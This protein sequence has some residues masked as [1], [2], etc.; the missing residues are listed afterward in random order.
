M[1]ARLHRAHAP[2]P[3][4]RSSGPGHFRRL[5]RGPRPS[6]GAR[7]SLGS[8]PSVSVP[9][10]PPLSGFVFQEAGI[11]E[12]SGPG[13]RGTAPLRAGLGSPGAPARAGTPPTSRG[14]PLSLP[15]RRGV[16]PR[17]SRPV[18]PARATSHGAAQPETTRGPHRPPTQ[19]PPDSA[20]QTAVPGQLAPSAAS[21]TAAPA[22]REGPGVGPANGA[23]DSGSPSTASCL[24]PGR[25]LLII[26]CGKNLV[27]ASVVHARSARSQ[28]TLRMDEIPPSP[29][30]EKMQAQSTASPTWALSLRPPS[31][32]ES[33]WGGGREGAAGGGGCGAQK[34]YPSGPWLLAQS[35][36]RL[37]C[38]RLNPLWTPSASVS[39][40][41]KILGVP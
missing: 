32:D 41:T 7:R 36:G 6:S 37:G 26:L 16:I 15:R 30:P 31:P 39:K 28:V 34:P 40:K 20:T 3:L 11:S 25:H 27:P 35:S 38:H 29:S 22:D 18:R 17:A 33:R 8:A 21:G 10:T 14:D 19:P 23:H 2:F 5:P 1:S 24:G 13:I 4:C 9:G 12:E